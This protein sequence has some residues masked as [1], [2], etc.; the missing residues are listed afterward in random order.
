MHY[1]A[2]AAHTGVFVLASLT[3]S[4]TISYKTTIRPNIK[5]MG[6]SRGIFNISPM[7]K[8]AE[9]EFLLELGYNIIRKLLETPLFFIHYVSNTNL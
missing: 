4:C 6:D 3:S 9:Y 1:D 7:G 5:T 8:S 2:A